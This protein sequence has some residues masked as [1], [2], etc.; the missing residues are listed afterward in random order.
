MKISR[1]LFPGICLSALMVGLATT[2]L[3]HTSL[4]H[5]DPAPDS[6]LDRAPSAVY[7]W[8]LQPLNP[9][10][11][12]SIF[13]AQFQSVDTTLMHIDLND[14]VPGR[15]TVDWQAIAADGHKTI[16]SYDF[17]VRDTTTIT[18]A[19]LIGGHSIGAGR[20]ADYPNAAIP[21][22]PAFNRQPPIHPSPGLEQP[23]NGRF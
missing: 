14:L 21:S 1:F 3:A 5:A 17:V 7:T 10:S 18:L 19:V 11:H 4:D 13:D 2:V 15:Y 12:L 8:F 9:G 20:H 6:I 22:G 16:G 23:V